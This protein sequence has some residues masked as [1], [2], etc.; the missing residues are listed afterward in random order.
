MEKT[1]IILAIDDP[2]VYAAFYST[3]S[4]VYDI[5]KAESPGQII[6]SN[7]KLAVISSDFC[8]N[9]MNICAS[10][11]STYDYPIIV[12][13]NSCS[14]SDM[15]SGLALGDDCIS[16]NC[17][18]GIIKARVMAKLRRI[19]NRGE[20]ITFGSLTLD[21]ASGAAIN[22]CTPMH[23]TRREFSIL[24]CLA[25][26]HD[27]TVTREELIN[28]VYKDRPTDDPNAL[29]LAI[30]RLKRKLKDEDTGLRIISFRGDGYLLDH[31]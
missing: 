20:V 11:R 5:F 6:N 16:P 23:L 3:L 9:G 24:Y 17:P 18:T 28:F 26:R 8:A 1:T 31:T 27:M 21:P 29:W 22:G 10:L 13:P 15:L 30:S 7:G 19:E 14:M 12:V 25:S 2:G 4:E